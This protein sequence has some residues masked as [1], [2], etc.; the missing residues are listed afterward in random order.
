MESAVWIVD[1]V[2]EEL[3]D[4]GKRQRLGGWAAAD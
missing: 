1:K 3:W 2:H 4:G